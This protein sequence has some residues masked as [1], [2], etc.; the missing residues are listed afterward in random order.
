MF[1]KIIWYLFL[2]ILISIVLFVLL[3]YWM[4]RLGHGEEISFFVT[5][6]GPVIGLY[7]FNLVGLSYLGT[8]GLSLYL[9][10]SLLFVI[11]N[12]LFSY[13]K[14]KYSYLILLFLFITWWGIGVLTYYY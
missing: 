13:N 5:L 6:M 4:L 1:K 3:R 11:L 7:T 14:T 10:G 9:I 8:M 2:Y 12:I